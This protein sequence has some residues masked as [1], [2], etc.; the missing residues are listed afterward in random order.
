MLVVQGKNIT[1]FEYM[2]ASGFGL[3]ITMCLQTCPSLSYE[4]AK[5]RARRKHETLDVILDK[6]SD[7]FKFFV[8]FLETQLL[9][10]AKERLFIELEVNNE[11]L[12]DCT[13]R[14]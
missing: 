6:Q 12:R 9:E 1:R 10:K 7:N 2:A 3:Q 13:N 14:N 8:C 4:L 11:S 5:A